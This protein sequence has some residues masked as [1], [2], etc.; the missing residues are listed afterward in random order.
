MTTT[1]WL[2][3]MLQDIRYALRSFR[4][5]PGFVTVALL[6]LMLGTGATSS[7]FSVIYGV[8]IS[9]YPYAKPG[10]IWAIGL[11]AKSGRDGRGIYPLEDYLELT[12]VPAFA[13]VMATSWENTLL[14]GEFAPEAF[15]G[16]LLS[17]NALNFL[18]VP[19]V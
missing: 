1:G 13:D 14:T 11:N 18:G 6:S 8:L 4:K 10:E 5:H 2:H 3:T 7:I 12:K 19:P 9:P 17:G 16:V 15:T